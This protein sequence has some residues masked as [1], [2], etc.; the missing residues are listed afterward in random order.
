MSWFKNKSG[1][2]KSE[3]VAT[4]PATPVSK[5][6]V[7]TAPFP[8]EEYYKKYLE[9]AKKYTYDYSTISY[10]WKPTDRMDTLNSI[11]E[12]EIY[13]LKDGVCVYHRESNTKVIS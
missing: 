2:G 7:H 5:R 13:P 12:S 11:L 6:L 8:Y 1:K 4:S 10:E 9:E 3:V